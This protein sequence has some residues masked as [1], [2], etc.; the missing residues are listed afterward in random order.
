MKFL[1]KKYFLLT[2]V[3]FLRIDC[4]VTQDGFRPR[5]LREILRE[6]KWLGRKLKLDFQI[7]YTNCPK[8]YEIFWKVRNV[9]EV[10]KQRNMIRGEVICTN[11]PHQIERTSFY[12]PHYVE[13]FLVKNK[14]CIARDR[15]DVPIE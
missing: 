13:C 8:P 1:L 14:V 3:F 6:H 10:A 2:F 12:G 7:M 5:F 15:I 11:N 9:G 4:T